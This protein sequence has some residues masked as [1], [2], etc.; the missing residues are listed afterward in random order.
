MKRLI[1]AA[2]A[3]A[4]SC[5]GGDTVPQKDLKKAAEEEYERTMS[6][7]VPEWNELMAEVC[8]PLKVPAD[9]MAECKLDPN[10]KKGSQFGEAR[11][12]KPAPATPKPDAK[13]PEATPA[14]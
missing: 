1:I 2:L 13:T 10:K 3:A 11:W 14:K 6:A 8:E 12:E 7:I 9:K 4:L 5:L